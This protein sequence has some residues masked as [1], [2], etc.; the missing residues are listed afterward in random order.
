MSTV[1]PITIT[2]TCSLGWAETAELTLENSVEGE[3]LRG[4]GGRAGRDD[5]GGGG[6]GRGCLRPLSTFGPT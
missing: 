6:G 2:L 3:G 5:T 4:E 1:V